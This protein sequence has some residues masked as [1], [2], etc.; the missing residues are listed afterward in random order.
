MGLLQQ[1]RGPYAKGRAIVTQSS[2]RRVVVLRV[3]FRR[4]REQESDVMKTL[5]DIGDEISGK[6][7]LMRVDFNVPLDKQTGKITNDMRIRQTLPTIRYAVERGARA[8]L[9]SHLGRPDGKAVPEL[10]MKSVA[11]RLSELLG[12]PVKFAPDCVGPSVEAMVGQMSDGEVLLLENVR[13]HAEEEEN[14]REFARKLA[15][16][17]DFYVND[18]FG[19]AHRAHASTE[20]VARL[21]PSAAGMLM[22]KEVHYLSKA[23]K[24]PEHPFVAVMGGAKVS[25]KIGVIRTLLQQAD[26]LLV[27]GAMAYTF[28]KYQ[29]KGVGNSK[30]E[31]DKL[32]VAGALLREAGKK[33]LLPID[34]VC[35]DRIAQDATITTADGDVPQGVIGLDIGPKTAAL[36]ESKIADAKLVVWNGPMGYFELDAFSEGTKRIARA[37]ASCKGI[38]IVGGGETA[39][40]VE[41]LGLQD[42]MSHVS[43]GGGAALEFLAGKQLP[44]IAVLQ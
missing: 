18:A 1:V 10:S 33:I 19:T 34:H 15:E 8:I 28:L 40:A 3:V 6:R 32:E 43:T 17:G 26:L 21:L 41:K 35:A 12:K 14:D 38:T 24:D 44:G 39:E 31:D 2:G 4:M 22:E 5:K 20:G 25:D 29:G 11:K 27:G 13:F 7:V 16:L 36:Y 9:M 37:M 30:V 42:R 23:I